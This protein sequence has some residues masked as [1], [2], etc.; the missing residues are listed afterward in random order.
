MR[1]LVCEYDEETREYYSRP[2]TEFDGIDPQ[3]EEEKED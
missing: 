1:T 3:Y 2:A